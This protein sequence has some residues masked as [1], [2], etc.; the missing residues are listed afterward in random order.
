M[1]TIYINLDPYLRELIA[2][3]KGGKVGDAPKF[4]P[5]PLAVTPPVGADVAVYAQSGTVSGAI[6]SVSWSFSPSLGDAIAQNVAPGLS[7]VLASESASVYAVTGNRFVAT[8]T[9]TDVT[10]PTA[11]TY[12]IAFE[13]LVNRPAIDGPVDL[14]DFTPP[15]PAPTAAQINTALG[16]SGA[17]EGQPLKGVSLTNT[18]NAPAPTAAQ[19]NTALGGTGAT[20]DAPLNGVYLAGAYIVVS[21][22]TE[23]LPENVPMTQIGVYNGTYSGS[24]PAITGDMIPYTIG[25]SHG[26]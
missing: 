14:V 4:S 3:I 21:D 5:L 26:A 12:A 11:G 6:A 16:G 9:I 20:A 22:S 2:W 1:K 17:A 24:Y 10:T 23:T 18:T 19:I 25:P 15:A 13:V 8:A 7:Q